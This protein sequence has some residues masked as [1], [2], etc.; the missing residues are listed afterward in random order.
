MSEDMYE[1]IVNNVHRL[2]DYNLEN[3]T[4]TTVHGSNG[5]IDKGYLRIKLYKRVIMV[6]QIIAVL[7][8]GRECIGKQVNHKDGNKLNNRRDNLEIATMQE[9]IDHAIESGLYDKSLDNLKVY[10]SKH[11]KS[12]LTEDEVR[13]IKFNSDGLTNTEV[14][15]KFNIDRKTVAQI[16]E[17]KTWKH[18]KQI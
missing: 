3:G 17:G 11:G 7:A 12:K 9:N 1:H 6:H 8:F 14:G 2:K 18:V 16:R 4:I 15:K 5:A 10:G 13:E